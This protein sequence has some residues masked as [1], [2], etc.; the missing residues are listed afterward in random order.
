MLIVFILEYALQFYSLFISILYTFAF[1]HTHTQTSG[2]YCQNR[3]YCVQIRPCA[4]TKTDAR[5]RG[6]AGETGRDGCHD[7][8]SRGAPGKVGIKHHCS[9]GNHG[10]DHGHPGQPSALK[11]G[12]IGTV[13]KGQ[14]SAPEQPGQKHWRL[15]LK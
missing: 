4:G 7:R 6:R 8:F 10:D 13:N 5:Q 12:D 1:V 3:R 15:E 2:L 14:R 11:R 9:H